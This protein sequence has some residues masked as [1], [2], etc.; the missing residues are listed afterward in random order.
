MLNSDTLSVIEQAILSITE[1]VNN[2]I[3]IESIVS[4]TG[5]IGEVLASFPLEEEPINEVNQ[6]IYEQCGICQEYFD[7]NEL[8]H[9]DC[10]HTFCPEELVA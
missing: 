10:N 8:H 5:I 1:T 2:I 7:S 4:I 6:I 3:L 9:L